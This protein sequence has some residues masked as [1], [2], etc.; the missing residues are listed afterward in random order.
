[1]ACIFSSVMCK[2]LP[3][4][5]LSDLKL[6][7]GSKCILF[8]AARAWTLTSTGFLFKGRILKYEKQSVE[9]R[10]CTV[11]QVCR[12]ICQK[13]FEMHWDITGKYYCKS[14]KHDGIKKQL[15]MPWKVL[16]AIYCKTDASYFRNVKSIWETSLKELKLQ[17][18]KEAQL[19]DRINTFKGLF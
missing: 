18:Y 9:K 1:M 6:D 3:R 19:T 2:R 15:I 4:L 7:V 11:G 5:H 16:S 12:N 13:R 10:V 14:M 17:R 8:L